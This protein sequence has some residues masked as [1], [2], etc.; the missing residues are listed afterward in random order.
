MFKSCPAATGWLHPAHYRD[1]VSGP[2]PWLSDTGSLPSWEARRVDALKNVVR[3]AVRGKK[4]STADLS[5]NSVSLGIQETAL[6]MSASENLPFFC[7]ERLSIVAPYGSVECRQQIHIPMLLSDVVYAAVPGCSIGQQAAQEESAK[8]AM[9]HASF[10]L[11]IGPRPPSTGSMDEGRGPGENSSNIEPPLSE[12][13]LL[14]IGNCDWDGMQ[15]ILFDLGSFGTLRWDLG[16]VYEMS[17]QSLGTGGC[18]KVLLGQAKNRIARA[19]ALTLDKVTVPQVAVKMLKE[20]E[21]KCRTHASTEKSIRKEVG[22]LARAHGHPNLSILFGVFCC[23][24]DQK[25]DGLTSSSQGG[26]SRERPRQPINELEWCIVMD[27]CM[28]GDL[29]DLLDARGPLS[30]ADGLEML[31][32]LLTGIEHLHYKRIVHRDVKCENILISNG[33]TILADMGIAA[34]LDDPSSMREM[35]GSPGYASPE[36]VL[37]KPYTEKVDIF[38]AGIVLYKTVTDTMPFTGKDLQMVL[39]KTAR[40]RIRFVHEV[41]QSISNVAFLFVTSLLDRNPDGRPTASAARDELLT[42]VQAEVPGTA[43]DHPRPKD[44]EADAGTPRASPPAPTAATPSTVPS[45]SASAPARASSEEVAAKDDE[46][47]SKKEAANK[48]VAKAEM[49]GDTPDIVPT[50][51]KTPKSGHFFTW[52]RRQFTRP[53]SRPSRASS[54]SGSQNSTS[55][56]PVQSCRKQSEIDASTL[57]NVAPPSQP[58]PSSRRPRC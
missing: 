24:K 45:A 54:S 40:C 4:L 48:D 8:E 44:R 58:R 13:W 33:R 51:P 11:A 27:L 25:E 36:V 37:K 2:A 50:P 1:E 43:S 6:N 30:L 9:L 16:D 17:E 56:E 21:M 34:C 5:K 42:V 29:H 7:R 38:A 12:V 46:Q 26:I 23:W 55:K 22:F 53:F 49:K 57:M 14:C 20:E 18:G 39:A 28:A 32:G 19:N 3:R 41:F 31:L 15:R 10:I 47:A 35:I 52:A